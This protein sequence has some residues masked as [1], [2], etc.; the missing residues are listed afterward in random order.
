MTYRRACFVLPYSTEQSR[1]YLS[2]YKSWLSHQNVSPNTARVYY[3]CIKHFLYFWDCAQLSIEGM[4][5]ASHLNEAMST[6]LNFLKG[7]KKGNS[8]LNANI[9]ALKNFSRFLGLGVSEL[10][11]EPGYPKAPKLL[12]LSEEERFLA[13]VEQQES[14]RDRALSLML[15]RT[16]LRIGECALL[17]ITDVGPGASFVLLPGRVRV[18]LDEKTMLALRQWLEERQKMSREQAETGLWLTKEGKSLSTGGIGYV[19]ERIGWQAN[20]TLSVET[21]RRTFVV[22]ITKSMTKSDLAGRFGGYI[23]KATLNRYGINLPPSR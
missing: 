9:N 22:K 4:N 19:I 5:D 2:K 18:S 15:L 10:K 3:S 21:L 11:R 17:N 8:T 23:S 6:Y 14:A 13:A 12:S 20:L 1:I 7:S 16:G